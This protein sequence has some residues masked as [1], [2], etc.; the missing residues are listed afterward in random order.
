MIPK[1]LGFWLTRF[2]LEV[3]RKNGDN[4]PPASLHH[5]CCD[6]QRHYNDRSNENFEKINIFQKDSEY[7]YTFYEACDRVMIELTAKDHGVNVN[8]ADPILPRDEEKLWDTKVI[9]LDTATGHSHGVYFYCLNIF[10]LQG[11]SI[12]RELEK[13]QFSIDF[14]LE[15]GVEV[16]KYHERLSK[17]YQAGLK[18]L[19]VKPITSE[20]FADPSNSRCVVNLFKKYLSLIPD[21]GPFYL[22]PFKKNKIE[23]KFTL[24]CLMLTSKKNLLNLG[25]DIDLKQLNR[26]CEKTLQ[27]NEKLVRYCKLKSQQQKTP[28]KT[29]L[30]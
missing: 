3:R 6:I 12:H 17:S 19:K 16:L 20:I 9:S 11:G 18:H 22:Q 25:L 1:E 8:R 10:S 28:K 15:T 26:T 4:Y 27:P 2:V 5:I 29:I 23:I 24:N 14:D 21:N 13:E 7:F 30:R